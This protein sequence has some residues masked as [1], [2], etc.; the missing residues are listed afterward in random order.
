M[1]GNHHFAGALEFPKTFSMR[2]TVGFSPS[3]TSTSITS[4]RHAT[5]RVPRRRSHSF[6]PRSMRD[7]F[8]RFTA[9]SPRTFASFFRVFTSIKSS[10][11]PSRATISTSPPFLPLKFRARILQFRTRSQ[12]AATFSP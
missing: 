10:C 1:L 7:R 12:S 11:L 5:W 8:L 4:K 9:A 2:L 3:E 6:A